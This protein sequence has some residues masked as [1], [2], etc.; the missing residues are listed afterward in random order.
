LCGV[1]AS[2]AWA[3][4]PYRQEIIPGFSTLNVGLHSS[5]ELVDLDGDGDLD[6]IVG[7]YDC[8]LFYFVNT[9]TSTSPA[10]VEVTGAP[11]PFSGIHLLDYNSTPELVDIDADGDLDAI[12][13]EFNGRLVFFRSLASSLLFANGFEDGSTSAWS[14]VIPAQ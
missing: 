2:A 7:E 1:S 13:G 5:P 10:F 14:F 6:A 3:Q 9:G 8:A 12:V 4:A 11:S